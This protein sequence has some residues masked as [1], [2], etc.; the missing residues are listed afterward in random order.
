M[1]GSPQTQ[2]LHSCLD[3]MCYAAISRPQVC[4]ETGTYRGDGS[5]L[6]AK[7]FRIVH[8]IELSSKWHEFSSKRLADV[9][10][11]VCHHGDSAEL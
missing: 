3:I 10:N 4:V 2:F 9:Q 7:Q 5:L 1:A 8:T 6:L 11:I